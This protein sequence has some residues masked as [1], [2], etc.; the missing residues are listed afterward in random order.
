MRHQ[1]THDNFYTNLYKSA[2][3]RIPNM[4]LNNINYKIK[5]SFKNNTSSN[6]KNTEFICKEHN[7]KFYKYCLICK[8]DICPQCNNNHFM[9][10]TLKYRDISLNENQIKLLKKEYKE[11]IDIFSNLLIKINQW[12]DIFNNAILELEE[13]IKNIID[14]I[15]KMISN[16]DINDINYKSIIEYRIIYSLFLDNKEEKLNNQKLIKIMKSFINLKNYNNYHY[17]D[18]NENLSSICK[19]II[20]LLNNSLNKGNFVQK[21]NNIIKFLFNNFSL[22]SNIN[23]E[24]KNNNFKNIGEHY[25]KKIDKEDNYV[26][27]NPK[28]KNYLNK[29]T[30]NIFESSGSLNFRNILFDDNINSSKNKNNKKIYER[31]KAFDKN[32]NVEIFLEK[33]ELPIFN[34]NS[35]FQSDNYNKENTNANSNFIN[36]NPEIDFPKISENHHF[37]TSRESNPLWK[38]TNNINPKISSDNEDIDDIDDINI[39]LD[40]KTEKSR[41]NFSNKRPIIF[42]NNINNFNNINNINSKNN[43]IN[44]YN[45]NKIYSERNKTSKIYQHKKFN[46]TLID[47]L[48]SINL[49]NKVQSDKNNENIIFNTIDLHN[50]DTLSLT[51]TISWTDSKNSNTYRESTFSPTNK[52]I[53]NNWKIKKVTEFSIDINKDLNIGF[54]LGNSECKIGIINQF[55]NTI[56]LWIPNENEINNNNNTS[57]STLISFKDKYDNIIIGD[58]AE[59]LKISNPSYSFFNFIK[60]IGKNTNEIVGKKELWP[61][62]IYNREETKTPY[63][64]GYYNGY[65]NKIYNFEDLLSLYLR[66]L[67][68]LLFS[69][70]KIKNE[71]SNINYIINI[72]LVITV[73]IRKI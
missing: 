49:T 71:N 57:I 1:R 41:N 3:F 53:N 8:E 52:L 29:S 60:F 32:K 23:K 55:S 45:I 70:I 26:Y 6:S 38:S 51:N 47:G 34:H 33:E 25:I 44:T 72:N 36:N 16:Y 35:P 10:D 22:L 37:F 20:T 11:Y 28:I 27:Y 54:E 59:E 63:I 67:F 39:D 18:A 5:K 73:P 4:K 42:N 19:E 24:N 7:R 50:Y 46:S 2:N 17:I 48:K 65:K 69:K 21:G 56:E 62:K 58:Q 15:S 66:K 31:K 61:Y 30:N 68:E 64:K 13:Y 14:V 43:Y 40:Y 9:H 12:K